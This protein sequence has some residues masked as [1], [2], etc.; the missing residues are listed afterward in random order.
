M[1]LLSLLDINRLTGILRPSISDFQ[2]M[3]F[4]AMAADFLK[5][6]DKGLKWRVVNQALIRSDDGLDEM[7]KPAFNAVRYTD[8]AGS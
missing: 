6:V 2:S 1:V 5:P 8:E 4:C 7:M 3:L